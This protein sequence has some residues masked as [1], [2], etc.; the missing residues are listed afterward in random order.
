M[1]GYILAHEEMKKTLRG[2]AAS[3][4]KLTPRKAI[5]QICIDCVEG[6]REVKVC[7]GDKL[8][9]GPC[10]FYPYRLGKGRPSVKLIRKYCL[11]CMCGSPKLVRHCP[12]KACPLLRYRFGKNPAMAGKLAPVASVI[13]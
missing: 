7:Q 6:A 13:L 9:D 1:S 2:T 5:R 4:G 10:L 12:S 3:L 8:F 11:Y